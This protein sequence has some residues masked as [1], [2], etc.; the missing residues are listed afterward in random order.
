MPSL[1]SG[2]G[3]VLPHEGVEIP[4]QLPDSGSAGAA[5]PSTPENK[6]SG[7]RVQ[8]PSISMVVLF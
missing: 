3:G 1:L 5:L 6:P 4:L 7:Q 2:L 8:S